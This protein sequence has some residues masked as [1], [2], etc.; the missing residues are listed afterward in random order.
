VTRRRGSLIVR[1]MILPRAW[2]NLFRFS[3]ALTFSYSLMVLSGIRVSWS[4]IQRL[5]QNTNFTSAVAWCLP[6][7]LFWKGSALGLCWSSG[8]WQVTAGGEPTLSMARRKAGLL[9]SSRERRISSHRSAHAR[10]WSSLASST[11]SFANERACCG[12]DRKTWRRLSQ[13]PRDAADPSCTRL[14]FGD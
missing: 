10:S 13:R 12:R 14:R 6:A 5:L 3:G 11:A 2:V 1:L 9:V 8:R 4:V 7:E